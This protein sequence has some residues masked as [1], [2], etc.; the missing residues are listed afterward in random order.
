MDV[1]E[2]V[3]QTNNNNTE[4]TCSHFFRTG[5]NANNYCPTKARHQGPDGKGYCAR[6]LP[7]SPNGSSGPASPVEAETAASSTTNA[8]KNDPYSAESNFQSK[9]RDMMDDDDS[10]AEEDAN[11]EQQ[12][13]M[14]EIRHNVVRSMYFS[15][16]ATIEKTTSD[17][18][19]LTAHLKED[20]VVNYSLMRIAKEHP[21]VVDRVSNPLIALPVFTATAMVTTRNENRSKRDANG[22]T[23]LT[24]SQYFINKKQH[25]KPREDVQIIKEEDEI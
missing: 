24:Q 13:E 6:H 9:H 2:D 21:N 14:E 11:M 16:I 4:G 17:L 3:Q 5:R 23:D 12:Q 18:Q 15:T 7:K 1:T 20:P 10:D 25:E 22:L 8:N 19:G